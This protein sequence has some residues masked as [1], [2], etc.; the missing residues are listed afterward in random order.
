MMDS[1]LFAGNGALTVSGERASV[2]RADRPQ[3]AALVGEGVV[4]WG[5]DTE[6]A[7]A[8]ERRGAKTGREK[9]PPQGLPRDDWR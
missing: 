9:R 2:C 4:E 5:A 1:P 7:L 8:Q 3:W 6:E